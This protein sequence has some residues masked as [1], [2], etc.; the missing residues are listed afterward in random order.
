MSVSSRKND[1]IRTRKL[2][3]MMKPELQSLLLIV[4]TLMLAAV[5]TTWADTAVDESLQKRI[6]DAI[7]SKMP[8]LVIPPG[9]Y[10][11]SPPTDPGPHLTI[12]GAKDL[13]IEATGVKLICTS[14]N[15]AISIED[16]SN[17]TVKGL[18]VDY[19]P[20]PFTQGTIVATTDNGSQIDVKIH[21]GYRDI[22]GTV[23]GIVVDP[24]SRIVKDDTW[25]RYGGTATDAGEGTVRVDWGRPFPDA[26]VVGDLISLA[27]AIR[28]PHGVILSGCSG[29]TLESVTINASPTFAV[30]ER[31]CEGT[32]Y[33]GVKVVPGPTPTG[34]TEPRLL[35]SNADGIHSKHAGRGPTIENCEFN[36]TGDDGIAINGDF[37][38]VV[39]SQDANTVIVSPKYELPF[40]VGDR[41]RGFD[42]RLMPTEPAKIVA[43]KQVDASGE[44]DPRPV[45]QRSLPRLMKAESLLKDVYEV[46]LDGPL[47][48]EAGDLMSSP[49][50]SGSGFVVRNNVI[51]SHRARGI[52]VKAS[53]GI[54]EGNTVE[55]STIAGIV[56]CPEAAHW[57]EADFSRDVIIRNNMLRKIGRGARNPGTVQAGAIS[58][59][60]ASKGSADGHRNITIEGN[61]I[62]DSAGCNVVIMSANGVTVKGNRFVRP[63]HVKPGSGARLGV[64]GSAMVWIGNAQNVTL[65]DN[66]ATEVGPLT[67][68][69]L[70]AA[71][72]TTNVI[73]DK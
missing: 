16:C 33:R 69:P 51:R 60:A 14:L 35:S 42:R 3:T 49:D 73:T 43:V 48:L 67:E 6:D 31:G 65:T 21:A 41:V 63:G 47:P 1:S 11:V 52:L 71:D 54:I 45:Q 37:V 68:T 59:V 22:S 46:T 40:K 30:L 36:A 27:G 17:V 23:R 29:M 5:S 15:L 53:D 57:L 4:A 7:A 24:Q 10:R 61:T 9:E 44:N 20:L 32:T 50:R 66:T 28:S 72:T 58:V 19:D 12:R 64:D 70:I 39:R 55:G 13:V 62:E 26:A 56:L 34:A 38:L 2:D 18:T 25:T 8:T